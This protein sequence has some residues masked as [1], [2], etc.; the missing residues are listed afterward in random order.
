MRK[1]RGYSRDTPQALARDYKLFA[2]ACEGTKREPEYFN[3]FSQIS[4]KVTVDIIESKV[5]DAELQSKHKDSSAPRWVLDRA[6]AYIEKE[7]LDRADD[8]WF[9]IDKDRWSI[10]QLREI[11]DYCDQYPNWHIVLSNPCFEVWLYFHKK[12]TFSGGA[13]AS[14]GDL[15]QTLAS[16]E[17]GGYHPYK[18]IPFLEDAIKNAKGADTDPN[19]FMPGPMETKVYQLG[20]ALLT[21]IGKKDFNEFISNRLPILIKADIAKAKLSNRKKR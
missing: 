2:I 5:T 17:T 14:C 15:K 10:E 7:G 16:M 9:V 20:E 13:T 12:S 11:A 1:K 18:F 6:I 21:F 4:R 19:H 3:L 8:L